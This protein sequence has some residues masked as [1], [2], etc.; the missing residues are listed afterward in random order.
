MYVETCS[1]IEDLSGM[2][3]FSTIGG[4]GGADISV[5]D[6]EGVIDRLNEIKDQPGEYETRWLM[7][8][9]EAAK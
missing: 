9:Q 1:A 4:L 5:A 7:K 3:R 8:D 6:M 2:A